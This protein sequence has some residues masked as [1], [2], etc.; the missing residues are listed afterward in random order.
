MAP[1]RPRRRRGLFGRLRQTARPARDSSPRQDGPG[2]RLEPDESV[3][4]EVE[5][6]ERSR[7][8]PVAA[9]RRVG[10]AAGPREPEPRPQADLLLGDDLDTAGQDGRAE[11]AVAAFNACEHPRRVSGLSR[12]LGSPSVNVRPDEE[13]QHLVAIVVAW[14]LCWYRYEVDVD[15]EDPV[16]RMV[17]QGTELDEIAAPDRL[18]NAAADELGELSLSA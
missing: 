13:V 7:A 4:G 9:S 16:V 2:D 15:E 18:P 8:R 1:A 5:P 12:S 14:E 11:R 3:E 6:P 17:D 10:Q